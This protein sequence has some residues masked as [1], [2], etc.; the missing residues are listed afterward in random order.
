MLSSWCISFFATPAVT[1]TAP[2][3]APAAP[4]APVAA[5]GSVAPADAAAAPAPAPA[6]AAPKA[7]P[8]QQALLTDLHWLVHQGHVIEFANGLLETAKKPLPKPEPAP[9]PEK[10]P[11]APRAPRPENGLLLLPAPNAALVG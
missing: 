11:K 9:R 1:E 4:E 6:P 3:P 7:T 5:E 8:E 10:A 2:A